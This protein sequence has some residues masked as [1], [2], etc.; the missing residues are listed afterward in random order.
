MELKLVKGSYEYKEQII[1]ML[2]E[3]IDYNENHPEAN[4]SPNAIFRNNY[5]DWF[6]IL[7]SFVSMKKEILW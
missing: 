3:W 2:K 1:D 6:R 7:L 5:E 4:T